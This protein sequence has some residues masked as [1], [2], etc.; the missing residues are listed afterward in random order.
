[1]C[2]R[3]HLNADHVHTADT[4]CFIDAGR[5]DHEEISAGSWSCPCRARHSASP[6]LPLPGSNTSVDVTMRLVWSDAYSHSYRRATIGSIFIALNAG[7]RPAMSP[8]R[9]KVREAAVSVFG[10]W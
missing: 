1:M 3:R 4:L 5:N 8:A 6:N 10:S 2:V 7:S 9:I